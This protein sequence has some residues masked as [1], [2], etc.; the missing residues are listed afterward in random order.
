LN[1]RFP[2]L[3]WGQFSAS[4][5]GTYYIKWEQTD[6]NTGQLVN[7]A[8]QSTG[9]IA[10]VQGGVGYPGSLPRWKHTASLYYDNGPWRGTLTELFQT[11]YKDDGGERTVGSYTLWDISGSY[12]GF[13]NWTLSV[14]IRN[15]L[16]TN[17]PACAQGQ[18]FQVGYD[19]TYADPR[20]RQYLGSV[21]YTFK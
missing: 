21:K 17:P 8:G 11:H 15:L 16:D 3:D 14:G 9:G 20:G 2:R 4:L 13:K 6:P 19:P 1:A 18:D 10:T 5:H 7:Y 12:A